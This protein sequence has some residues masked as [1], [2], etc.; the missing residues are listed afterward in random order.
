[1]T[2]GKVFNLFED[3]LAIPPYFTAGYLD[4][5]ARLRHYRILRSIANGIENGLESVKNSYCFSSQITRS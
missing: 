2:T 5:I 1:M 3:Q 4:P